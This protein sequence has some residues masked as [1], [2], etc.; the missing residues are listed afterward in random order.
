MVSDILCA[1]HFLTIHY[2]D[3]ECFGLLGLMRMLGTGI[4]PQIAELDAAERTARDH[5]LDSLL[6]HALGEA[7]FE[8]RFR[9]SLLDASDESGVI[10][11][12]LVFALAPGEHHLGGIDDDDMVAAVDMGRVGR[13]M[14]AAQPHGDQCG[15]PADDEATGIDQDPLFRYLGGFC[16]KRLHVRKSVKR[17]DETKRW[18]RP[19][20]MDGFLEKAAACVNAKSRLFMQSTQALKNMVLYYRKNH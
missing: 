13:E 20:P 8:D 17:R 11:I 2:G 14:L 7:A 18:A 16:R 12:D 10:V 5:A 9:R 1:P 15:E 19:A 3:V 4:D 6:D